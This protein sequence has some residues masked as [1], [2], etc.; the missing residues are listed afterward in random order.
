MLD[1]HFGGI[2]LW[3]LLITPIL[4]LDIHNIAMLKSGS[5]SGKS[6]TNKKSPKDNRTF[7]IYP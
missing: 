3:L 2:F 5:P 7:C 4:I 1:K 6:R